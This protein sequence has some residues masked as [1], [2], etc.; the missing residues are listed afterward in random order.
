MISNKII[1]VEELWRFYN[2]SANLICIEGKSGYFNHVNPSFYELLHFTEDELLSTSYLE[3]VHPDDREA[4]LNEINELKKGKAVAIFSNRCKTKNGNYKWLSWTANCSGENGNIYAVGLDCTDKILS[5]QEIAEEKTRMDPFPTNERKK[6]TDS[7]ETLI[8]KS[9]RLKPIEIKF[10]S[11]NFSDQTFDKI[12]ELNILSIIREQLRNILKHSEATY[13]QINLEQI[14]DMLFLCVQDN[15]KGCNKSTQKKGTGISGI[16]EC[17]S[18]YK[19]E[20]FIDTA[21]GKG[22]MLSVTFTEP[23]LMLN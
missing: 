19:G 1:S 9:E 17:A 10:F 2:L 6:L 18:R 15:G 23:T 4:T 5:Q 7:I 13:A 14:D 20:V 11:Q 16:I 22:Y 3:L 21:P 12:L 8:K